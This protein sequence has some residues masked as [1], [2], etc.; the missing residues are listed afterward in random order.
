MATQAAASV[1]RTESAS[2]RLFRQQEST[3][4]VLNLAVLAAL[5]LV[6][7]GF[8]FVIGDP[9]RRVLTAI[10]GFFLLQTLELIWLQGRRAPISGRTI[11][12]YPTVSIVL[13]MLIGVGIG[14]LG[15]V[16]D[17]HYA[18]LLVLPI[19]SAAYRYSLAGILA[20]AGAAGTLTLAELWGFYLKHPPLM[21]REFY[22]A[23]TVVMSYFVMGIVV[24]YLT[25]QLRKDRQALQSS[26]EELERTRDRLVAEEKLAAVGRLSSAIA[27]EIRNPVAMIKSSTELLRDGRAPEAERGELCAIVVDEARRLERLTTDFLAYARNRPPE[28]RRTT[29]AELLGYLAGLARARAQEAG[30][31]IRLDCPEDAPVLLDPFQMQQ[32]L[33]NL[34]LNAL[35]ASGAGSVVIL[36]ARREGASGVLF[37]VENQGDP[38]PAAISARLF[39]PFFSTKERGTGLGLAIARNIAHS[40]GG[41]LELGVNGGGRVRFDLRLTGTGEPVGAAVG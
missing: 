28:K 7:I 4:V 40:H 29:L 25:G 33:L 20:T 10:L 36:G 30:I 17:S 5:V 3:F 34:L 13:K 37:T 14:V 27:H 1:G 35:D 39:E 23:G 8:S 32:A 6:H 16:E 18:V 26:L 41:D 22:E 24:G 2:S 9:N 19:I 11:A 38:I 31:E 12:V 21:P 15:G